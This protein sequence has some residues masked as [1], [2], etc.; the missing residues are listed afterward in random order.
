M[1]AQSPSKT[2]S[3]WLWLATLGW[4][5]FWSVLGFISVKEQAITLGGRARPNSS[6]LA[7]YEGMDAVALGLL[8]FGV[9]AWGLTWLLQNHPRKRVLN[10][11]L[12]LIWFV[13]SA[14][15]LAFI[16]FNS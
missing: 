5:C 9:A 12:F 7:H 6:G 13:G 14:A 1:P 15:C 4:I 10:W 16:K 2:P 8:L 11:L 3:A